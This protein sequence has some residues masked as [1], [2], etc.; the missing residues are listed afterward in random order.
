MSSSDDPFSR[1]QGRPD[2]RDPDP[3][4]EPGIWEALWNTKQP[5]DVSRQELRDELDVDLG[6]GMVLYGLLMM[7]ETDGIPSIAWIVGGLLVKLE[8]RRDQE[9][10]DDGGD[11]GGEWDATPSEELPE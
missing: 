4:D 1:A 10:Y 7:G 3:D 11:Q 5:E 9:S 8:Q 6:T 2:D